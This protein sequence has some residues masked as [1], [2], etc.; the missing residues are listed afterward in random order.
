[1]ASEHDQARDA[2]SAQAGAIDWSGELSRHASWLRAVILARVGEPQAVEEVMQEVGLAAVKQQSPIKDPS[3]VA[4]WLYRLAVTQS[5]LFRRRM[6]RQRK[7]LRRYA[8]RQPVAER[9]ERD[10]DPLEWLLGDERRQQ[11]RQ[12]LARLPT[13]DAEILLLKYTQQWSYGQIAE[14]LGTTK[15]AVESRL[16]RARG[17]LR[18]ELAATMEI[19]TMATV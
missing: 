10:A 18:A 1:M 12:C 3:K 2:R 16:H 14:H 8:E 19:E 6:G 4:P 15:S 11:V 13:R 17:R 5:L 7:L 9:V